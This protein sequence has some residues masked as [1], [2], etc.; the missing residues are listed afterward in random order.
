MTVI[1]DSV[2]ASFT[3]APAARRVLGRGLDLRLDARVC[4]RLVAPSCAFQGSTPES[5]LA[6]VRRR[7]TS[8]G[9]VVVLHVGYNDG[10]GAYDVPAMLRALRAA[11]VRTVLW[12]TLRAARPGYRAIN[13]RIRAAARASGAVR[14]VD[15]DAR[16]AGR[17]WFAGDGLHLTPAGAVALAE[18]LRAEVAAVLSPRGGAEGPGATR[19]RVA[20]PVAALAGDGARLWTL[21]GGRLAARDGRTGRRREPA[22]PAPPGTALLGDG[23]RTWWAPPGAGL[24]RPAPGARDGRGAAL[25]PALGD[26]RVARVRGR[27][28]TAGACR[29]AALPCPAAQVLVPAGEEA[30]ARPVA[31]TVH[32]LA[33]GGRALWL[34]RAAPGGAAVLELRGGR[35]GRVRRTVALA[36]ARRPVALAATAGRAWVLTRGGTLLAVSPGGRVRPV[37]RGASAVAADGGTRLWVL[38]SRAGEV[39]RLEPRTGR[40]LT[41]TAV[42]PGA[43]ALA[44][45]DAAVWV[46]H[47]RRAF[48]ERVP[49]R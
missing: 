43:G 41:R 42:T 48:L 32:A 26:P 44:L 18:L 14:V 5:A 36:P 6:L 11:R 2:Q 4:R 39:V 9:P 49:I 46:A 10:P 28:W 8:L 34:A 30:A 17:P 19:V 29:L 33:G 45:T 24:A 16:S 22:I 13:D 27:V 15:W 47:P 35:D 25:V 1:G 31:G 21:A 3:Y 12:V 7:G 38:R 20:Q 40:P 37:L 23:R